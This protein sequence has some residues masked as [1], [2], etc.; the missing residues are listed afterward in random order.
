MNNLIFLLLIFLLFISC[1]WDN[2]KIEIINNSGEDITSLEYGITTSKLHN[3]DTLHRGEKLLSKIVF[4][5][6]VKGDG[7]YILRFVR[8][9]N[10]YNESF[11]YYTNGS[12]LNRKIVVNIKSDTIIYTFK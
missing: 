10:S 1:K 8:D 11:G 5:D 3:A 4:N 6:E 9:G 7:A 2:P 12:T